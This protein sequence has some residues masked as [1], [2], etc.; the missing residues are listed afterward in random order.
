MKKTISWLLAFAMLLAMMPS[1]L[2]PSVSAA[3]ATFRAGDVNGDHMV[4]TSD[5]RPLLSYVVSST[6]LTADQQQAADYDFNGTVNTTDAKRI[7]D[8]V[9]SGNPNALLDIS[10]LP[11]RADDWYSPVQLT[12][13]IKSIV[14]VTE[15]GTNG[16]TFTNIGSTWPYAAYAYDQKIL[17][18]DDAYIEYDLTV[19][20]SATSINLYV[21]GS[22]PDLEGDRVMDDV[23]GRQYFKLNS[24]IS[25]T[26]IDAGSGDLTSGTY[27]GKVRVGDLALPDNCRIDG[28]LWISGLKVYAVGAD[29]NALTIRT[30]QVTGFHDPVKIDRAGGSLE[31]VR[32]ALIDTA[33]T[34]GLSTLTGMELYVNGALSADSVIKPSKDNKKIYNTRLY[35][36]I[37]NYTDGYQLDVPFDWQ[38]DFSLAKLRT[39]YTSEH[40]TLNISRESKNPYGNNADS[41]NTYLTEWINR[42]IADSAFLSANNLSY[43]RTPVTSTTLVDGFEVM[44]YDIVINDNAKIA[45]PYYSIAIVRPETSYVNFYLFVLKSDARTSTVMEKL[46][47][48]FKT[49]TQSGTAVNS[50][51]Q[52]TL[53]E[54]SYWNAETKAYFNKLQT[55]ETTDWGFFSA[56]MVPKSDSSYSSQN[57]K[58]KAEYDRI[59]G[60]IGYDYD[61]M[62]TYTHLQYGSSYN[63]FPTDMANTY[64]GGNGFNGKPV[65]QF[66]YQFTSNNNTNLAAYTPMYDVLRGKH[67]AQFRKLAKDIK[68]YKHP[69]LFRL[70]NEM[71][72][73]WTSYCG[74]VTLLDPDIF[75][76]TWRHLYDIFEQEGVDN[77][78]WIFNPVT[79]TTPYCSWGEDLCYMP[80]EDYVHS[81][82][83]TNYEM[84]NNATLTSFQILYTRAYA[85]SADHFAA[86]P[87]IISEFAAG[88]G[89]EKKFDWN[90]DQWTDTTLGRN[91]DLQVTWIEEMF[92]CLNNKDLSVNTFCK[93]I[94]GAVWFSV[95]DYTSINNKNYVVNYL[96]LDEARADSLAAFKEG[97]KG[98]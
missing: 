61:I 27:K 3:S 9:I 51:G 91:G 18:P 89:G 92:E 60:A 44:Q 46:L 25:S 20:C 21:G 48:S 80:G 86:H 22:I 87:W 53:T 77:C 45:Q 50:Q 72:T 97:L 41:W 58:I 56:S 26:N 12:S 4:A 32:P 75:I 96:A 76:E 19:R 16:Q 13:G 94:K 83:L 42:Y 17:V 7:L 34:E 29:K 47:R 73:D 82:G 35:R 31:V 52:Y 24:Y 67:D 14:D 57:K 74:M 33:E 93:N 84:G 66:T 36:R 2:L 81:L 78:I 6:E 1:V 90:I 95:N 15:N 85:K 38:E 11:A 39:R 70:N 79:T 65:L 28:M 68:A 69:V 59:S 63:Q 8:A 62:P 49:V 64:A 40:Y 5:V 30:L 43:T 23:A 55:Q 71:N 98:Q 54:P 88:A 37:V 10:L